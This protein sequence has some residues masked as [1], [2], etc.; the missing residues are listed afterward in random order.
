MI[1]IDLEASGLSPD[2]YPIE[3]AWKC[4]RTGR[5]DTFLINPDS[6]PEWDYWDEC[7]EELH[8]IEP[9]LLQQQGI[10]AEAACSRLNHALEGACVVSDAHAFD[11]FWLRRLFEACKVV[12][13]F[14]LVGLETVLPPKQC[15]RYEQIARGQFRRHRALQ[16]VD[17][18]IAA[19]EQARQTEA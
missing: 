10:S 15:E 12:P 19:I 11:D 2:S 14:K 4:T 9:E 3:I 1:C 6:V 13:R 17:D 16:D 5:S 18:L 8:G 7:A